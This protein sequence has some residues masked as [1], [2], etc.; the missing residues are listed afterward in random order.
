MNI[1]DKMKILAAEIAA[2]N[3]RSEALNR[4]A[5]K[6]EEYASLKEAEADRLEA[7]CLKKEEE[8]ALL[9]L[10]LERKMKEI[11]AKRNS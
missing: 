3:A 7:E 9:K 6:Y 11:N 8:I 10:Q 5:D 1:D 2:T 4:L